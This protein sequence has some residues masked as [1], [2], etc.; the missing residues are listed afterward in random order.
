MEPSEHE[1]VVEAKQTREPE[2][3]TYVVQRRGLEQGS[4]V[5][6]DMETVKVPKRSYR[7]TVLTTALAQ[8]GVTPDGEDRFRVLDA[9]AAQQLAVKPKEP[10]APEF[11]V[12]VV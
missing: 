5:W 8:A 1:P 3:S 7:S 12:R 9:E 10:A 6:I 2:G 4:I 11:E